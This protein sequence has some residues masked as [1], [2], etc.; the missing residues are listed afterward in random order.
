MRFIKAEQK[1][2]DRAEYIVHSS[3]ETAYSPC[4]PREVVEFFLHVIHTR[5]NISRDI[6]AGTLWLMEEDGVLFGTGC[7]RGDE[8]ARV[9]LLPDYQGRG[10]GSRM[11]DFLEKSAVTDTVQLSPSLP[12]EAFYRKR[13]YRLLSHEDCPLGNGVVLSRD[14]MVKTLH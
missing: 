3:I 8:I 9:Y 10:Y 5:E 6:D 2:L 1:H 4:Y 12:A 14:T 13:G 11:M 7:L